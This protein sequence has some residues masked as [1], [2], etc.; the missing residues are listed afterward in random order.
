MFVYQRVTTGCSPPSPEPAAAGRTRPAVIWPS[1]VPRMQA[2]RPNGQLL[3]RPP[4]A[5]TSLFGGPCG[6]YHWNFHKIDTVH[7]V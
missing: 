2:A 4:V 5:V 7:D 1:A 6:G 3:A